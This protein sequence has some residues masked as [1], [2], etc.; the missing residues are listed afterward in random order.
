MIYSKFLLPFILVGTSCFAQYKFEMKDASAYYDAKITM[1]DCSG[2]ECRG[3][4]VID[5][6]KKNGSKIDQTLTS[7]NLVFYLNQNNKISQEEIVRL[8]KNVV[9]DGPLIFDDFNFD[10][11]EDVAVKNGNLGNYGAASYDVYV[12]NVTK[13]KFVPSEELT[14]LASNSF[15]MFEVDHERKRLITYAKSGAAMHYI[16]EFTVIPNRGLVKVYEVEEDASGGERVIVTTKEFKDDKW[17]KTVKN[18]PIEEY[19]K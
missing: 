8:D 18:Y 2:D 9:S 4:A 1:E 15:G 11:T 6:F 10:G 12:Y 13:K 16:T 19:Y 17:I 14:D 3:K 5:L 7:E